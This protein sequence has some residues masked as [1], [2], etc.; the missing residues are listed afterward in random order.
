MSLETIVEHLPLGVG[1]QVHSSG[2]IQ[3]FPDFADK[4]DS[5]IHAEPADGFQVEL[6]HARMLITS[7]QRCKPRLP[8]LPQQHRHQ[9]RYAAAAQR[10]AHVVVDGEVEELQHRGGHR[11]RGGRGRGEDV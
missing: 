8:R 11:T 9:E 6:L 3:G 5:L 7:V 2:I 10:H 1:E 4:V